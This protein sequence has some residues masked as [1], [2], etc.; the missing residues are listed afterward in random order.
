M[1]RRKKEIKIDFNFLLIEENT[2]EF[3]QKD[4]LDNL[5]IGLNAEM[6][7]ETIFSLILRTKFV[8]Y[9]YTSPPTY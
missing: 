7:R 4:L 9:W 3:C 1:E 2:I 8:D 6:I 5:K